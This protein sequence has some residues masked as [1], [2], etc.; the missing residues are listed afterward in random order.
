MIDTH[1]LEKALGMELYSTNFPG[2]GGK[3]KTRFEDFVVEEISAD[4]TLL[5]VQKWSE[6]VPSISEGNPDRFATFTLQKMGLST[7][8]VANILAASLK[9]SRNYVSYAGLKDKRAIT[10]QSMSVP[11]KAVELLCTLE[12]SRINIRD[13]HYTRHPVQIGDLWGNRFTILLRDIIPE[14][15]SALDMISQ[16]REIPLLNYFGVQ[17]F[18]LVRPNTHLVGKAL[19]KRDFEDAVRIM[20]STTSD[21]ESEELTNVRLEIAENLTPTERMIETLPEDMGYEK[22]VMRELM[23]HPADFQRA[24]SKIPP[25]ILTLQVHAYQS[26]LFNH[27]LSMR[28]KL[29]MSIVTPEVGDFLIK[30]D[31]THSGRDTW[32][33]VTE[34]TL[35][36]RQC[37]VKSGKYGLA[38]PIPGY[39]TKLP[40]VKQSELVKQT[41]SDEDVRLSDFRNPSMKSLDSPG[42]LH[43]ASIDLPDFD[44]S[45]VDEGLLVS[46]SLRKGSYATVVMREIMKNHPINRV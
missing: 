40:S 35:E 44:A 38:L 1:P 2:F 5:N 15:E 13:I 29:G 37:Q 11:S 36:E 23:K 30:L 25:R 21:Y 17:R 9:V 39:S 6:E 34:S 24:V 46:F 33:Y 20:L 32:V 27:L 31:E 8:D 41:L 12:L 10:V 16:L 4:R 3:L 45:C 42:G 26:Y 18:G 7:M 19:I 43:L 22:T 28:V 14:C